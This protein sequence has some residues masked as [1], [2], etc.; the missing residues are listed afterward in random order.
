VLLLLLFDGVR[1]RGGFAVFAVRPAKQ[2][3]R[4][5]SRWRPENAL[6]VERVSQ[7]C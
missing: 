3:P 5:A 7:L 2:M 1:L 4:R 6:L